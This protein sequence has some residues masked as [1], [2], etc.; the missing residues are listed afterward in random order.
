MECTPS[1]KDYGWTPSREEPCTLPRGLIR[2]VGWCLFLHWLPDDILQTERWP[3]K[4]DC[5]WIRDRWCPRHPWR[6]LSSLQECIDWR[7]DIDTDSGS[8]SG[9]LRYDDETIVP[10]DGANVER[11]DGENTYD[12]GTW[13]CCCL[14]EPM[15]CR[16]RLRK[17]ERCIWQGEW[18]TCWQS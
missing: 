13:A 18:D 11:G 1:A 3:I 9:C 4:W 17:G 2:H 14:C 7:S 12:A 8:D 6:P 15:G 10:N 16:F 5:Q